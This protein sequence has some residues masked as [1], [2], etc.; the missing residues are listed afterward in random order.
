[1]Y[2]LMV[3]SDNSTSRKSTSL[4]LRTFNLILLSLLFDSEELD[5]YKTK[6]LSGNCY[7]E[8]SETYQLNLMIL[9]IMIYINCNLGNLTGSEQI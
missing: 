1:M 6:S 5:W 9:F 3:H 8:F 2:S 7:S 4:L